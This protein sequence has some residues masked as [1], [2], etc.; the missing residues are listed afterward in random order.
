[1]DAQFQC[2]ED[3]LKQ[4]QEAFQMVIQAIQK[5]MKEENDLSCK[6]VLEDLFELTQDTV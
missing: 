6:A 3:S 1:M 4:L 5:K 2:V